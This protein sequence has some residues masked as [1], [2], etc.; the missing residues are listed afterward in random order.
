MIITSKG[1]GR[2]GMMPKG[3][4]RC[5]ISR[6]VQREGSSTVMIIYQGLDSDAKNTECAD[7]VNLE[8]GEW[9]L[10]II[11]EAATGNKYPQDG[12]QWDTADVVG[13]E[14]MV[15]CEHREWEGQDQARAARIYPV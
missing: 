8:T 7:F 14:V 10:R 3:T 11:Y 5:K 12:Q 2:P 6:F 4:W 13:R 9:R 15:E 1:G